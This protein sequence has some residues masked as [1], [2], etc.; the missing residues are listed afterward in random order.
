M[1]TQLQIQNFK[2]WRDTGPMRFAPLTGFFGA[3]SSGKT[4][5][6]QFLL[7]LKQTAESLDRTQ[8]LHLGD[9]R[10]YVNLGS[11][12]DIIFNHQETN[13]LNF[14]LE[15]IPTLVNR[16]LFHSE[17]FSSE[18]SVS[19]HAQFELI[20]QILMLK[21]FTY[22][23]SVRALGMQLREIPTEGSEAKY[24]VTNDMLLEPRNG[25]S[26]EVPPPLHFYA[27]PDALNLYYQDTFL[28]SW[29]AS[30]LDNLLG[31]LEYL[32]PLRDHPSRTYLLRGSKIGSIGSR[33]ENTI[34][35]LITAPIAVQDAVARQLKQLGLIHSFTLQP[36]AEGRRE[37]ELRVRQSSSSPEVLITDVGFGVSQILPVLTLCYYASPKSIIILEQPEIHLHPAVQAG[38]A[39][40][41]IDAIK[42]RG[43]QIILESHSEHLLRRLQRRLA[44]EQ[45][46]PQDV[47]LYFTSMAEGESKREELQVDAYGNINNWPTNFFG[48]EMGDLVA[49]TE[50]AMQRQLRQ[51]PQ[52]GNV[53]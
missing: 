9:E 47:A 36:V 39:D 4:S 8:V 2:S 13:S 26:P 51:E 49:M 20:N 12:T 18:K 10:S 17:W 21:E 35:A 1:I 31:S 53:P 42:N 48:D 44:E 27:F 46:S 45:L 43:V 5:I 41:F 28:T 24:T 6:L 15:W 19:F 37:Y 23:Q 7:L 25:S 50:A 29:L 14:Q 30:F 52:T 3:N 16:S 33:G 32:G 34:P 38:L 22:Q 40:V 11:Y